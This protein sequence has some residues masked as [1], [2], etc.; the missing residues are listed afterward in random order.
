[1]QLAVGLKT[2]PIEYR[3][4]YHWLFRLMAEEGIHH[5]QLGSFAEL[6]HLPDDYF[7]HL[8]QEAESFGITISSVFTA[9]R[10]LG[11]FFRFE[12][13]AW[14]EVAHRNFA[15][16][17]EVA[18]LLGAESVGG[19]PGSVMR[20]HM[21]LKPQGIDRYLAHMKELMHY[22]HQLGLRY[23]AVEPM[24][25]LAEPPTLPAEIRGLAEEL[26]AYHRQHPTT[27]V[28]VGYCV[29][30]SHG[31]ADRSGQVRWSNVDL[32]QAALPYLHH[33][34][35]K[36][37]DPIF[38]ATFG[39]APDERV[40]GIVDVALF[41]DLLLDAARAGTLPVDTVVAYLEL[42]GPKTGRD[43]SDW[44]LEDSLR[45]S[46]RHVREVFLAPS[47]PPPAPGEANHD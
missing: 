17:I 21:D 9:H 32:F 44:Q 41:R 28:P 12:H 29:D 16:M 8:R 31:Y 18:A 45:A 10:E 20:D 13:P 7:L 37:T 30:I 25:C 1:M 46:L 36:N 2:D 40:R 24:S 5:A 22:A 15:R 11:G 14:A 6:Y 19:N 33:V 39:F 47:S 4:T 23:L 42:G 35:L 34:H 27:T 38:N 43:Y 3:F 26:L